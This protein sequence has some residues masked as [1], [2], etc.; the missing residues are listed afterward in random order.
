MIFASISAC[1]IRCLVYLLLFFWAFISCGK[2][3]A[4]ASPHR[5]SAA[6]FQSENDS[7][8]RLVNNTRDDANPDK[9]IDSFVLASLGRAPAEQFFNFCNQRTKL[10]LLARY[11]ERFD[12]FSNFSYYENDILLV[13]FY[14]DERYKNHQISYVEFDVDALLSGYTSKF[15]TATK[16]LFG[17]IGRHL[18]GASSVDRRVLAFDAHPDFE[19]FQQKQPMNYH[20]KNDPYFVEYD[21]LLKEMHKGPTMNNPKQHPTYF[22]FGCEDEGSE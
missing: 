15:L 3:V 17:E 1:R 7:L 13:Y 5:G 18:K 8:V 4:L 12:G 21:R 14:F 16:R 11:S 2:N 22:R 20:D 10:R 6:L 9:I 19:H